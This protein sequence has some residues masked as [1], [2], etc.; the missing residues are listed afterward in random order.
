M[1]RSCGPGR[2][3]GIMRC[4]SGFSKWKAADRRDLTANSRQW[5]LIK[6]GQIISFHQRF[7][8]FFVSATSV[9]AVSDFSPL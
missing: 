7:I 9:S 4:G 8:T 6:Q 3:E 2:R 1:R 5:M